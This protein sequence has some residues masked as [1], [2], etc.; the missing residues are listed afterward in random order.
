MHQKGDGGN[1]NGTM[2]NGKLPVFFSSFF[3]MLIFCFSYNN[4]LD[5]ADNGHEDR[6]QY[7]H[8]QHVG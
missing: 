8:H 2:V 6:H 3:L 1:G 4:Y 5:R 7:Q